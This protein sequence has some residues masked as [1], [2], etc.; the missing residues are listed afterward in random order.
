MPTTVAHGFFMPPTRRRP[1][2]A[3]PSRKYC[4]ASVSL[5]TAIGCDSLVSA[6]V[7]QRPRTSRVPIASKAPSDTICQSPL[8]LAP[9]RS[10]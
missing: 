7:N 10:S 9:G 8:A 2:T 1:P 3:L 4:R 6:A 5:I